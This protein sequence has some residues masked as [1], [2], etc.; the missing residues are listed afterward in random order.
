MKIVK[1][2]DI[3]YKAY[4]FSVMVNS[5]R[6]RI[7]E[8]FEFIK[9]ANIYYCIKLFLKDYFVRNNNNIRSIYLKSAPIIYSCE[10]GK[11]TKR[12]T[13]YIFFIS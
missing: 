11:N 5:D 2:A 7:Y 9:K 12:I 4:R 13:Y 1:I 6:R 3:R 10:K 8:Q